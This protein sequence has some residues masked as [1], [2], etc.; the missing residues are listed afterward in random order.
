VTVVLL[1]MRHMTVGCG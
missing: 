1:R